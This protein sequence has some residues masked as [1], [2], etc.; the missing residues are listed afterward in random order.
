MRLLYLSIA[1]VIGIY[2]GSLF[3]PPLYVFLSA[4]VLPILLILLGQKR[5]A[6]LWGGICFI[7]L[8]GGLLRFQY[9]IPENTLQSYNDQGIAVIRGEV[10]R[11]PSY[12]GRTSILRL[13]AHEIKIDGE[14][15]EVSG[16]VLIYTKVFPSYG[17]GD[18]L[19][20]A[21]ELEPL[22]EIEDLDYRAYLI[23]QGFSSVMSYPEIE[24]IERG[25]LFSMRN[26]LSQSL[27][28]ALPEPQGALAQALLLGNRSHIP[29]SLMDDFRSTG[30]A[31]LIA[32]SGLHVTILTVIVL[33]AGAWLFGR[34]RPIY[35][36]I[37]LLILWLYV[38]LTGMRPPAFRAGIMFSL[39]LATVWL[40]RPRSALPSLA[41]A[42]VI[43]VGIDPSLLWDVSFQLS[44]AAVAGVILLMP[45]FQ[46][47]GR[48]AIGRETGALVSI[49]NPIVTTLAVTLAA[50]I[51]TFPL[52]A[53]YFDSVSLVGLP[54]T[55]FA[56]LAL[57]GVIISA[58]LVAVLGLFVPILSWV[59]GW[60]AWLFLSCI[61][62]VIEG[63]GAL[64]FASYEVGPIHWVWVLAYYGIL[65]AVLS[66]KRLGTATSKLVNSVKR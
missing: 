41:L 23:Q 21:G 30:T 58:F 46:S 55:F 66:R 20:V 59:I 31:H 14:W 15:E 39:F 35:I 34:R 1:W 6:F 5:Q 44:F 18:R 45:P 8:L 13:S 62:K 17:Q 47:M 37:T 65:I 16:K 4:L 52:I 29:D 19:Q 3:A 28:E 38:L 27:S 49:A 24:F 9:S 26:R 48:K 22:T 61:I 56:L 60:V 43:M 42:A 50:I 64:P 2:L 7:F 54:T 12:G 51:A 57:P 53:Y 36:L 63:F 10:E 11:D 32:I 25:W 40:G 33:S